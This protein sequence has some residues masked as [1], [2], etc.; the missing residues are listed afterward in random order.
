[1]ARFLKNQNK[2][3]LL[4]LN[5]K[6]FSAALHILQR[7]IKVKE[8]ILASLKIKLGFNNMRP[9]SVISSTSDLKQGMPVI[10][11]HDKK[12]KISGTVSKCAEDSFHVSLV[13]G[14]SE[15]KK[16]IK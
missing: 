1:M 7:K 10:I 14:S 8:A 11:L 9:Y 16:T 2:K 13:Q 12:I 3:Y 5:P 4:L 15:I 6:T